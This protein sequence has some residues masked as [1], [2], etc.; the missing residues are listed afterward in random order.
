MIQ[1]K[2]Q[3]LFVTA[4]N[5]LHRQDSNNVSN[6]VV[7]QRHFGLDLGF[8]SAHK[9]KIQSSALYVIIYLFLVLQLLTPPPEFVKRRVMYFP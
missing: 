6:L 3:L 5:R 8:F 2:T 9:K 1:K 4:Q 7:F